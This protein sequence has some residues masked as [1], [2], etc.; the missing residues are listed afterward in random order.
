MVKVWRPHNSLE[1]STKFLSQIVYH[2][3][4][5]AVVSEILCPESITL[6]SAHNRGGESGGFTDYYN[7]H[8]FAPLYVICQSGLRSYIASRI[9]MGNGFDAY[10]FA[11]GFRF[12]DAVRNDKAL[13]K[14]S[15]L[16]GM[17]ISPVQF[18]EP[19][20]KRSPLLNL[21]TK[22]ELVSVSCCDFVSLS[23]TGK[24]VK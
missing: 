15:T 9:L 1:D 17:R 22:D 21:R 7:D 12:Y 24:Y 6:V 14:K 19:L 13:N 2:E 20:C 23:N 10:N 11:G 8:S 4:G 18:C 5:H 3:A 16:C